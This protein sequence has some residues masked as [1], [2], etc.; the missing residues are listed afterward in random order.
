[1]SIP[2]NGQFKMRSISQKIVQLVLC[3]TTS[4][5]AGTPSTAAESI[6]LTNQ[7]LIKV[8]ITRQATDYT[9]GVAAVQSVVGYYGEDFRE[10]ILAQEMRS[11]CA[12]GTDYKNIARFGRRHG[13]SVKV[14]KNITL[15]VLK[16]IIDSGTPP[17]CLIQ[18]WTDHKAN[19]YATDWDDGH[20]VVAIGYDA[21]NIYFMDPSTLGNY[22]FIPTDEFLKRWHDRT[23]AERLDH[24]AM[25][26]TKPKPAFNP[27]TIQK[28]E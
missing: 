5:V 25:T 9:C 11:N 18:A 10:H 1:M 28:M 23:P 20:Y 26:M 24:F 12:Q 27:L 15:D 19:N 14:N 3:L 8:P 7:K 16:K 21:K 17:I 4:T 22:T 6:A 13:Y 2:D